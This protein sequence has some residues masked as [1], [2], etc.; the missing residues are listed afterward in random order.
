MVQLRFLLI[1]IAG[2]LLML[3]TECMGAR[4]FSRGEL[5]PLLAERLKAEEQ[6]HKGKGDTH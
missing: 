1:W 6:R 4:A 3:K 2:K 5:S